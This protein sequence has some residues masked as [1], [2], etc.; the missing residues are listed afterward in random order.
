VDANNAYWT[1]GTAGTIMRMPLGGGTPIP[2]A[3]GQNVP[4]TVVVDSTRAYWDTYKGGTVATAPLDGGATSPL[5]SGFA[6]GE[7]GPW[8][9]VLK[10]PAVYW[11]LYGGGAVMS[12]PIGGGPVT[13][14]A[15]LPDAGTNYVVAGAGGVLA[16]DAN[17]LY[18]VHVPEDVT[19]SSVMRVP[20]GGGTPDTL[21]SNQNSPAG[22]AVDSTRIY[23]ANFG[24]GRLMSMP[25]GGGTPTPLAT[26]PVG[27]QLVTL[28]ETSVYWTAY[29][30]TAPGPVM[31]VAK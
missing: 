21:A 25:I 22:I 15:S 7:S 17:Y 26:G 4:F 3:S 2:I 11:M 5:A 9:L 14:L 28:D 31:K 6:S 1:D 18:W 19:Q 24:D 16:L 23:W 20:L 10:N 29:S 13:P 30:T 8:W 27:A 12:V